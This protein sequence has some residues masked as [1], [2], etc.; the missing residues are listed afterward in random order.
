M[1]ARQVV[2]TR[3]I[4]NYIERGFECVLSKYVGSHN[5][6]ETRERILDEINKAM[7]KMNVV[8]NYQVRCDASNN[9][10]QDALDGKLN[11]EVLI[12]PHKAAN[13]V[14]LD[15]SIQGDKV[16]T[17]FPDPAMWPE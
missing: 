9:S 12:Q 13:Y 10:P 1:N 11:V 17:T 15:V 4:L 16:W 3:R 14:A 6:R 8:A 7:A 5:D 2:H